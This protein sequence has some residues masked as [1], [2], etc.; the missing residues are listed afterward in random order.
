LE[1]KGFM[2]TFFR[3]ALEGWRVDHGTCSGYHRQKNREVTG[4]TVDEYY[5]SVLQYSAMNVLDPPAVDKYRVAYSI[6]RLIMTRRR[7]TSFLEKPYHWLY[8]PVRVDVF[9]KDLFIE[10]QL[11]YY[12]QITSHSKG[13]PLL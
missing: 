13:L 3:I 12:L 9:S 8:I 6:H 7:D 4:Y 11:S 2:A 10:I 5:C 1:M